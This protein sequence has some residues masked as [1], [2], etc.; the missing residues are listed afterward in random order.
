MLLKNCLSE[1]NITKV[2]LSNSV[3]VDGLFCHELT[4]TSAKVSF[5]KYAKAGK[6]QKFIPATYAALKKIAKA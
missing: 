5:L 6:L 1:L 3:D 4:S 2:T